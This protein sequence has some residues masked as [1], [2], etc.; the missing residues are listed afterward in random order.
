MTEVQILLKM[1][2]AVDPEDTDSSVVLDEHCALQFI[3]V[4]FYT[5]DAELRC[6]PDIGESNSLVPRA[7]T[8]GAF[9]LPIMHPKNWT[10]D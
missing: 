8:P 7:I 9:M 6:T 1:I 4:L 2:V 3:M 5:V 10:G